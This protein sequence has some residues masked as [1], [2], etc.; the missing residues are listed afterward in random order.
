[1]DERADTYS[2][3]IVLWELWT[4]GTPYHGMHE[5][6]LLAALL[7]QGIR[8]ELPSGAEQLPR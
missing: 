7:M 4:R 5:H 1:M 3:G 6:A 2:F 8:P